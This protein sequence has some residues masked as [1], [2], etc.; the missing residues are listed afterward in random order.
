MAD[1]LA[2][3]KG[4]LTTPPRNGTRLY[5]DLT[6]LVGQIQKLHGLRGA[7]TGVARGL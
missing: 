5:V 6:G 2:S 3:T 7:M 1:T 4:T